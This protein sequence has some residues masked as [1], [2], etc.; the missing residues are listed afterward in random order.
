M[1]NAGYEVR[2]YPRIRRLMED[3]GRLGRDKHLIHGL[4]EMDVTDARRAIR[5]YRA[6]TGAG[7]SFMA[8]VVACV[9]R[10]VARHKSIQA[11]RTL[12]ITRG[13]IARRPAPWSTVSWR[14]ASCCA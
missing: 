14:T 2:A 1:A 3:G 7:L 6:R 9:G 12:Q 5:A 13:D 8:F 4:F 11:C 10:A